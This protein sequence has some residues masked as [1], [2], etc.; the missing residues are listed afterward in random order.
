MASFTIPLYGLIGG[1]YRH[2][3]DLQ[4]LI[5]CITLLETWWQ[6][7]SLN[8]KLI[9]HTSEFPTAQYLGRV[10]VF[11]GLVKSYFPYYF[12]TSNLLTEHAAK[13]FETDEETCILLDHSPDMLLA[14]K[15]VILV[16]HAPSLA[17]F[18]ATRHF[19][20]W[21]HGVSFCLPPVAAISFLTQGLLILWTGIV[22]YL[23]IHTA[24]ILAA[25]IMIISGT[26]RLERQSSASLYMPT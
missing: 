8:S 11:N 26:P 5:G 21:H 17:I 14:M 24:L 3:V 13:A 15:W 19:L 12:W 4:Y 7:Q 9:P 23:E 18:N 6:G 2:T 25:S 10:E 16:Q 22:V 1:S 20:T